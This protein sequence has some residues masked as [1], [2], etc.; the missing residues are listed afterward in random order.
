MAPTAQDRQTE[1]FRIEGKKQSEWAAPVCEP[2]KQPAH[3]HDELS[4][5][6]ERRVSE[7]Y[8]ECGYR[9]GCALEDC[10][11]AEREMLNREPLSIIMVPS[12]S[13]VTRTLRPPPD[14][15]RR[16]GNAE[17]GSF[18][19]VRSEPGSQRL[20]RPLDTILGTTTLAVICKGSNNL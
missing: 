15:M 10:V 8:V 19:I 1:K 2:I 7:L 13:L 11:D 9:H 17:S 16:S 14:C 3:G 12:Q 20:L 4:A 6:I 18:A 5:S